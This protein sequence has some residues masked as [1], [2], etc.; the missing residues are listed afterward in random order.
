MK[1]H[2]ANSYICD[3]GCE[4]HDSYVDDNYCDCSTCDDEEFWTCSTCC[5][6]E[7]GCPEECDTYVSCVNYNVD[8][9]NSSNTMTSFN[10]SISPS[11]KPSMEPSIMPSTYPTVNLD[12]SFFVSCFVVSL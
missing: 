6:D 12:G 4:I 10:T 1:F 2:N 11:V 7:C 9:L 5:A 8:D 3:D